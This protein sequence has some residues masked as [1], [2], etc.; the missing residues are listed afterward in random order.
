LFIRIPLTLADVSVIFVAF[1]ASTEGNDKEV[2]KILSSPE[3]RLV[4]EI[5]HGNDTLCPE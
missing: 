1:S 3:T 2:V 5:W 4:P